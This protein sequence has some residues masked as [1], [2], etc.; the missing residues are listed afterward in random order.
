[1]DRREA[2]P[3]GTPGPVLAGI[4]TAASAEEVL[5]SA[6]EAAQ[7]HATTLLVMPAGLEPE[8]EAALS[9]LVDRWATKYPEVPVAVA[10]HS[11]IDPAIVIAGATRC[12]C[13][14]VLAR[15]A[16]ARAAAVLGAVAR[17]AHCPL[18]LA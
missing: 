12:C 5:R 2:G 3:A 10:M 7:D 4:L 13:L 15:P 14:A 1:M 9:D 11:D 17:R 16:D 18:M 8:A 6:F